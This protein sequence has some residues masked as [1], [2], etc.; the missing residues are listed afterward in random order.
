MLEHVRHALDA[1]DASGTEA[2]A[3]T[4]LLG[5]G[6]IATQ[7][8]QP[9]TSLSG[10]WRTRADLASALLQPSDLLLL[11]E[12]TNYLDLPAILWLQDYIPN[13]FATRS[14]IVATH[15]RAFVDGIA[16]ELLLLRLAPAKTL[17]TFRGTLTDYE[18]EKR[19]QIRRMTR[20]KEA[21]DRKTKHMEGTIEKSIR[22]A[23][24]TGDDKKL[25]QAASR[26]KK[27]EERTGLE[28]G[29]R[30]GR[31]KLNRDL[32][33]WHQSNR[34]EIEIPGFDPP[35]TIQLPEQPEELRFP[36]PLASF[37]RVCFSYDGGRKPNA[38]M[39]L[40]DIDLVIHRG[41]RVGLVGLNGCGKSTL[42][43]LL[44]AAAGRREDAAT[45]RPSKGS[46]TTHPRAR[47]SCYTQHSV[48]D[49]EAF[50]RSH[51]DVTALSYLAAVARRHD[52]PAD[53]Q[54]LRGI[55]AKFG[56]KAYGPAGAGRG[57]SGSSSSSSALVSETPLDQ[58]S[59]GQR[60]RLALAEAFLPSPHLLI[61]DEVTTHLDADTIGALITALNKT[62]TRGALLV[63]T[64]D[65]YFMSRVVER[66]PARDAVSRAHRSRG[67]SANASVNSSDDDD[68]DDESSD[69]DG[70]GDAP[71]A[72][73][74]GRV[75]R[76]HNGLLQHLPA[77]MRQYE[78]MI[79]KKMSKMKR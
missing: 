6:F 19:R 37:E 74:P 30:G 53:E 34:A 61:L 68:D 44:M 27:L 22:A 41:E 21:Q 54:S 64:H 79:R 18:A 48:E 25:K 3:R 8:D 63:V 4:I 52:R 31:F 42:V 17:E 67:P 10:G 51:P 1:M 26:K 58:L 12:P 59:G 14:V 13:A 77:G 78:E 69:E 66:Q 40:R 28:V 62:W 57:S 75:Y 43:G 7:I 20:M 47:I 36:G 60:V 73:T 35:V 72:R 5:L 15:D 65:R 50:G 9:F 46:V 24:R 45:G 32:A 49:L 56:L 39:V 55:L 33:G 29:I 2:R 23:K 11:D 16:D 38:A 76:I 70:D 71:T